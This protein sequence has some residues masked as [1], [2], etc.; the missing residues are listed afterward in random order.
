[1]KADTLSFK[2]VSKVKTKGNWWVLKT[3]KRHLNTGHSIEHNVFLTRISSRQ[4]IY[5]DDHNQRNLDLYP[6]TLNPIVSLTLN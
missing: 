3:I 2:I 6:Y 1:M 5:I 4:H